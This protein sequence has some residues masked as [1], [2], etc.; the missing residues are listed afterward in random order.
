MHLLD[1]FPVCRNKAITSSGVLS[2]KG[3]CGYVCCARG[4]RLRAGSGHEGLTGRSG[5]R[6]FQVDGRQRLRIIWEY[7]IV[8]GAEPEPGGAWG[9]LEEW[10]VG[11]GDERVGKR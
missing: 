4:Q 10:F 9:G 5:R 1:C 6:S 3:T 11:T 2:I 8:I 7:L